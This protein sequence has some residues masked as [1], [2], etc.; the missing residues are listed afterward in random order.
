MTM[1]Q[2]IWTEPE[3]N[4]RSQSQLFDLRYATGIIPPFPF[5]LPAHWHEKKVD[6]VQATLSECMPSK[7]DN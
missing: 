2:I 1:Q 6:T 4:F 3:R 7:T 5:I